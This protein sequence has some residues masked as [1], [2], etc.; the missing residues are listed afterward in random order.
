MKLNTATADEITYKDPGAER[1]GRND[2]SNYME[3]FQTGMPG[4]R[5]VIDKVI[6]H[7][8]RCLA[9][10]RMVGPDGETRQHGTSFALCDEDGR[11]QQITGFFDTNITA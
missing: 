8:T 1:T 3:D 5:F 7:H 2:L 11:L 9:I 6:A 10:W 4:C